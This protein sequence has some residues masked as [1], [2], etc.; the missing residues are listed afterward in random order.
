MKIDSSDNLPLDSR[1]SELIVSRLGVER[2]RSEAAKEEAIGEKFAA[3]GLLPW[4]SPS[5]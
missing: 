4:Y 1:R 2:R 5:G 3:Y